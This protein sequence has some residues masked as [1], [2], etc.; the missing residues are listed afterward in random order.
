M[1]PTYS[2]LEARIRRLEDA[3][4]PIN[5][6]WLEFGCLIISVLFFIG[7]WQF[8]DWGVFSVT[9][10]TV[11]PSDIPRAYPFIIGYALFSCVAISL[12]AS[13]KGSFENLKPV[14]GVP[15]GVLVGVL[16]GVLC[17]VLVGV[18]VGVLGGVLVGVPFGVL[19]EFSRD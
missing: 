14:S 18:L 9:K 3:R 2:E 13:L 19:G 4:K 12:C 11:Q 6:P 7:N 1:K 5:V 15:F 8:L 10:D 16:V 17:G